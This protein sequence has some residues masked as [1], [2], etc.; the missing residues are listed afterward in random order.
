ME[1]KLS[2]AARE[3]L[4]AE[5]TLVNRIGHVQADFHGQAVHLKGEVRCLQDKLTIE[6]T[7]RNCVHASTLIA[8]NL[9]WA[10]NPVS[11]I[12][13]EI[14]IAPFPPGWILLAANGNRATL[15]VEAAS[16]CEA[17]DLALSIMENWSAKGGN[18]T[19]RLSVNS[20]DHDESADISATLGG[21]PSPSAN[22]E[23]HLARIGERWQKLALAEGDTS[24]RD[25]AAALGFK[26]ELWKKDLAPLIAALRK[27]HIQATEYA[28]QNARLEKLPLGHL[29]IAARGRHL[30]LKGEVG[31]ATLKHALLDQAIH[32]FT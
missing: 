5:Q 17:R 27:D 23:L 16:D 15:Y 4:R 28:K 7:V 2:A 12:R 9:G 20:E 22:V 6:A 24:L 8:S 21:L 1:A 13:N 30:I 18:I 3:A 31:S 14:Q 25:Q 11:A 29:F 19:S 26:G 32:V 10:L